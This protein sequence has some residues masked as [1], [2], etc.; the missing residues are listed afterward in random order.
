MSIYKTVR[1]NHPEAKAILVIG[2]SDTNVATRFIDFGY[3]VISVAE[4][5]DYWHYV[6]LADVIVHYGSI[7]NC[8]AI[9]KP[10]YTMAIKDC[11]NIEDRKI[12]DINKWEENDVY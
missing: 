11:I 9:H 1:K 4:D 7:L 5:D 12:Y 2:G 6:S 3:T 10:V 8:Y